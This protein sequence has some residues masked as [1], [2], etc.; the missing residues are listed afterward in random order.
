VIDQNKDGIIND[1]DRIYVGS[2]QPIAF[3]GWNTQMNWK[4]WDLNIDVFSNI[5]NKV[6][7]GKKTVRY[8]GSYNVEYEVAAN[9]WTP[10]NPNNEN[11]RAFN[12][13]PKPSDYFVESGS[14]VRLNNLALGYTMPNR[15]LTKIGAKSMRFY[16]TAQ[17]LFTLK[18]Y[19]GY[20][21]ELPGAPPEAGIELNIYPTSRTVITGVQI[22]F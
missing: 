4:N 15:L 21:P 9:R 3:V 11:P 10:D 5:G 16:L 2:Y 8:G 12:G 18:R 22:Q 17:N 19:S 13:V 14:F 7:N 20:T 6:F 1:E